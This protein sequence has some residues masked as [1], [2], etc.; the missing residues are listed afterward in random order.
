[1]ARISGDLFPGT[2][3]HNL[4]KINCMEEIK[5]SGVAAGKLDDPLFNQRDLDLTSFYL[6]CIGC[7]SVI[8]ASIK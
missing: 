4:C 8:I 1:M 7:F 2:L 3:F 5:V 6:F